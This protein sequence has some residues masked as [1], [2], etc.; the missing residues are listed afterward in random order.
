MRLSVAPGTNAATVLQEAH[1]EAVQ[2]CSRENTNPFGR[3]RR[4]S[5]L[6]VL[7]AAGQ[8]RRGPRLAAPESLPAC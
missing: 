5:I 7:L 2:K 1:Q 8:A 4:M 3:A 6:F